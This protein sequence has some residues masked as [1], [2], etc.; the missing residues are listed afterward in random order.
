MF[1]EQNTIKNLLVPFIIILTNLI[2]KSVAEMLS[3]KKILETLK[4]NNINYTAVYQMK[5]V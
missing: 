5:L 4:L 3:V 1:I 2:L